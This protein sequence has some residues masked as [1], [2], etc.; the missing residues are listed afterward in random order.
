[1][2][3]E[4]TRRC[5]RVARCQISF[6]KFILEAYDNVAVMSTL[7]SRQALIQV[8]IAPG[9]ETMVDRIMASLSGDVG[10]IRVDG[11]S[12]EGVANDTDRLPADETDR[13]QSNKR[14]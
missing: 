1:M 10:L 2:T 7:D 3:L 14:N 8:T 12:P 13:W 4:T 5:Y 6:V 11:S 9:C